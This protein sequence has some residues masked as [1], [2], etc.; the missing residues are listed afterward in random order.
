MVKD[1]DF[2]EFDKLC[3]YVKSL[4]PEETNFSKIDIGEIKALEA[5][6]IEITEDIK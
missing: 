1:I 6:A 5:K 2:F 4:K 3:N